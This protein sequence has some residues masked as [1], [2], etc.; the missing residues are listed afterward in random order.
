M[1]SLLEQPGLRPPAQCAQLCLLLAGVVQRLVGA[2]QYSNHDV[3]SQL[4]ITFMHTFSPSVA[5]VTLGVA[6]VGAAIWVRGGRLGLRQA[7]VDHPLTLIPLC[8]LALSLKPPSPSSF[9][10]FLVLGNCSEE[11]CEGERWKNR[12]YKKWKG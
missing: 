2:T 1:P 10:K 3:I 11:R 9:V 7:W 12:G 5:V 4:G 6:F 8:H